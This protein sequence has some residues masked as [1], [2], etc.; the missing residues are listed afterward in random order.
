MRPWWTKRRLVVV[1]TELEVLGDEWKWERILPMKPE[2]KLV[3]G[4]TGDIGGFGWAL[5]DR[6]DFW[7]CGGKSGGAF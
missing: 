2:A 7:I 3:G 5:F 6:L 1:L 4:K